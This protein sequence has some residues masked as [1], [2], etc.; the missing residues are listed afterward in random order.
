MLDSASEMKILQYVTELWAMTLT[1]K[2]VTQFSVMT[3]PPTL[4]GVRMLVLVSDRQRNANGPKLILLATFYMFGYVCP[5]GTFRNC[6]VTFLS[7]GFKI[8]AP[9][10]KVLKPTVET[11]SISGQR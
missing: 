8:L 11:K 3:G 7:A 4:Q 10:L 5:L 6:F 9:S 1:A 2:I